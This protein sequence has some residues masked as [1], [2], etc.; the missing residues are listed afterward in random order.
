MKVQKLIKNFAEEKTRWD[1]WSLI[2][3]LKDKF[4]SPTNFIL[5]LYITNSFLLF[6]GNYKNN[7]SQLSSCVFKLY[8]INYSGSNKKL[9]YLSGNRNTYYWI[10]VSHN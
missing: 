8:G 7:V 6:H 3:Q 9:K 1:T 4:F 5:G 10:E 2:N